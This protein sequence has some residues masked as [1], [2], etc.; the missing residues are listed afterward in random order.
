VDGNF[1][2]VGHWTSGIAGEVPAPGQ[3]SNAACTVAQAASTGRVSEAGYFPDLPTDPSALL[4]YLNQIDV[5]NTAGL[6]VAS[7]PGWI[8][9]DPAKGVMYLP[10]Q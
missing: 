1:P 9:N 2:E 6:S 4:S 8:D 3:T 5:T 7:T 10:Q